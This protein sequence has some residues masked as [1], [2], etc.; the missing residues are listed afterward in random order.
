[1][2]SGNFPLLA[3]GHILRELESPVVYNISRDELYELDDEAFQFLKKC[4]GMTPF[5]DLFLK[6]KRDENIDF[7]LDEGIINFTE[8]NEI[9]TSKSPHSP[10][11]SLRYLLL[12]I[13]NKCNLKCK[14]CYLPDPGKREI[15]PGIFEKAVQQFEEMGG[16]K[17]M[18]SGGEPLIHSRFWELMDILPSYELNVVILS[19]GTQIDKTTARKLSRYVHEVQISID[20]IRSH[21]LRR[22]KGSY[23]RSMKGISNLN[24]SGI[25]VS[26]AT[27][28][29]KYNTDEF[30]EMEKLFLE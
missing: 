21:D 19:N 11:P 9:K 6:E 29:H 12:N 1:M 3:P 2:L 27:M 30:E 23:A 28:V 14:H 26:I 20:G 13:T 5:P 25:P 22:G 7:M 24:K 4:N 17:L 16:L 15:D 18:I 10:I 8:G